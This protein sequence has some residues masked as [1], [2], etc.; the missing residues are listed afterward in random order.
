M[1]LASFL[2]GVVHGITPDEHTWPITFAYSVGSYSSRGGAKAGLLFSLGFTLQRSALAEIAYFA[3]I[4][5]FTTV[6]AIGVSY[7]VVGIAMAAAGIYFQKRTHYFHWHYIEEKLGTLI[8]IHKEG[9]LQQKEELDHTAD[10]AMSMDGLSD[11]KPIPA[12]LALVHGVVAGFGFGA[13]ALIMYTVL[14]PAMPSPWI[15]FLPGLLFGLGTM[16]MQIMFGAFFGRAVRGFGKLSK[17]GVSYVARRISIS[18]LSYGGVAF[19]I[20]G[21]AVLAFPGIMGVGISTGLK[22]HN[23]DSLDMGF[24]LVV[25][26]VAVIGLISYLFAVRRARELGYVELPEGVRS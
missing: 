12:R 2:L 17:K 20:G 8:G 7:V 1:L 26:S 15:A 21:L 6:F 10:P 3:L 11:D 22:I 19:M 25:I 18:V 13:F 5:I 23:L 4:G 24:F 16:V 14:V 9:S